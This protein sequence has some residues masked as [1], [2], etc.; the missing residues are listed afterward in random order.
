M[1]LTI[2]PTTSDPNIEQNTTPDLNSEH[3][4]TPP[5]HRKPNTSEQAAKHV[6]IPNTEHNTEHERVFS[7]HRTALSGSPDRYIA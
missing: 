3:N 5:E 6:Q 1:P 2:S 7:E 4:R